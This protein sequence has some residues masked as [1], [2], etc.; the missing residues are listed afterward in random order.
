MSKKSK[1]A[2]RVPMSLLQY[3]DSELVF[4]VVAAVGT[5]LDAFESLLRDL[6]RRKSLALELHDDSIELEPRTGSSPGPQTKVRFSPFVGV[7]ARRYF[8]LFSTRLSTGG[9]VSR[10]DRA[11]GKA[12]AWKPEGAV[13][14]VFMSSASYLQREEL[15]VRELTD[16]TKRSRK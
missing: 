14:R 2:E 15:A 1:A 11:T 6:L 3:K 16:F 7:A 9:T 13:P 10:K 5:D 12:L 8:D 4:G